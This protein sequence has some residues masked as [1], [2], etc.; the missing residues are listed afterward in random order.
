MSKK[1][2]S[3]ALALIM[4]LTVIPLGSMTALAE[5]GCTHAHDQYCGYVEGKG[6]CTHVHDPACGYTDCNHTHDSKCG[7][8]EGKSPCTHLHDANC[9]GYVPGGPLPGGN[10]GGDQPP[11]PPPPEPPVPDGKNPPDSP[12]IEVEVDPNLDA[13]FK[14]DRKKVKELVK[15]AETEWTISFKNAK[16][17][18]EN[19]Y[20]KGMTKDVYTLNFVAT[21]KG[22]DM[23]GTYTVTTGHLINDWDL[24]AAIAYY[25]GRGTQLD[26]A[27]KTDDG[28]LSAQLAAGAG[29]KFSFDLIKEEDMDHPDYLAPVGQ[30]KPIPYRGV[31][32]SSMYWD[33]TYSQ[34]TIG[35]GGEY[36]LAFQLADPEEPDYTIIAYPNG[37]AEIRIS[38]G[39]FWQKTITFYGRISKKVTLKQVKGQ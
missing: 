8:A 31:A 30:K 7:Y 1:A 3:L 24:T 18:M 19:P 14:A 28:P 37:K 23:Y 6:G 2:L 4:I 11:P 17:T 10:P 36:N 39:C 22:G 9:G 26:Y 16:L 35:N 25:R 12:P 29:G 15:E 34:Y 21:K 13:D 20:T 33:R 32:T 27:K 5:G 38:G